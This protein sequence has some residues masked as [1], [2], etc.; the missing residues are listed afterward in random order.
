MAVGNGGE[1][2][3][4]GDHRCLVGLCFDRVAVVRMSDAREVRSVLVGLNEAVAWTGF[5]RGNLEHL[6]RERKLPGPK[7]RGQYPLFDLVRGCFDYLKEKGSR[8]ASEGDPL[9]A[10]QAGIAEEKWQQAKMKTAQMRNEL[11]PVSDVE[12]AWTDVANIIRT[13]LIG[14]P[15]KLAPRIVGVKNIGAAKE[16][17]EAAINEALQEL[18]NVKIEVHIIGEDDEEDV[19]SRVQRPKAAVKVDGE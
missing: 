10:A 4:A 17:I 19:G 5:G 18:N 9:K 1:A 3:C 16:L 12:D 14:I 15:A 13:R 6:I 8:G 2:S 11:L 7:G